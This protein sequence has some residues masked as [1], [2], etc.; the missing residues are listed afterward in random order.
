MSARQTE[1][2]DI[3]IGMVRLAET[4]G[5]ALPWPNLLDAC[6]GLAERAVIGR[7][8][9]DLIERGLIE[10]TSNGLRFALSSPPGVTD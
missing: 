7:T 1:I 6:G 8:V 5:Y 9:D 3:V 4:F 2:A 10:T